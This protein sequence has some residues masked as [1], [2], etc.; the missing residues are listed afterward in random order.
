MNTYNPNKTLR[1]EIAEVIAA[2]KKVAAELAEQQ[3]TAEDQSRIEQHL[4]DTVRAEAIIATIREKV[5]APDRANWKELMTLTESQVF[6][7][8]THSDS[9]I[10]LFD[11]AAKQVRDYCR[12]NEIMVRIVP[13]RRDGQYSITSSTGNYIMSICVK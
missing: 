8:D 3:R 12:D 4:A 9:D 10:L 1:Q 11:G 13:E 5:L 7:P 6:V 2:E